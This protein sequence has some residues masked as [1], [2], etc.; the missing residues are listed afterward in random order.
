[1]PKHDLVELTRNCLCHLF[2]FAQLEMYAKETER[3][4]PQFLQL[5][6]TQVPFPLRAKSL[7]GM[8]EKIKCVP[9]ALGL[10]YE[11]HGEYGKALS[12]YVLSLDSEVF[13]MVLQ[14]FTSDRVQIS[15]ED[16]IDLRR[17]V[18]TNLP[19]FVLIDR[20]QTSLLIRSIFPGQHAIVLNDIGDPLLQFEYLKQ[21]ISKD[22]TA[23]EKFEP[24]IYNQYVKVSKI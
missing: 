20:K 11:N 3:C 12:A 10:F 14:A 9:K 13:R 1:M 23:N 18:L 5:L 24:E 22:I 15:D 19:K 16:K 7:E 6:L 21:L 4:V 8:E 17:L 2:A